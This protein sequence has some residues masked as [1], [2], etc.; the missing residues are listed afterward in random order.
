MGKKPQKKRLSTKDK[1]ELII[2]AITAIA[3]LISAFKS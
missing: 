1:I 2:E 3:A